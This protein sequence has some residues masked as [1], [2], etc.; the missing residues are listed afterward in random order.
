MVELESDRYIQWQTNYII[1]VLV[2]S[3]TQF[4]SMRV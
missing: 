1:L 2:K 3:S 4:I